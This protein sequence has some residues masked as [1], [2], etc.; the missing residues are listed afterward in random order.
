MNELTKG[1]EKR[2]G[3][4][5]NVIILEK[6]DKLIK[7]VQMIP[8]LQHTLLSIMDTINANPLIT[9]GKYLSLILELNKRFDSKINKKMELFRI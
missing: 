1:L 9:C 3:S 2:L 6:I 4:K 5:Q 7:S 8:D